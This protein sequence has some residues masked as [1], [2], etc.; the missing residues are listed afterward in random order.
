M[1]AL[2]SWEAVCVCLGAKRQLSKGQPSPEEITENPESLPKAL[3]TVKGSQVCE[4]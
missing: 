4:E 1:A 3:Y 2:T